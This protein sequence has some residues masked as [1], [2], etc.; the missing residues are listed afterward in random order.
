VFTSPA[1]DVRVI[2]YRSPGKTLG[3]GSAR[4]FDGFPRTW[5]VRQDM[6]MSCRRGGL[7]DQF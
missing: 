6:L 5:G 7:F 1:P 3:A 4:G 2:D